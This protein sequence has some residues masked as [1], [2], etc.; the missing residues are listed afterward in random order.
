VTIEAIFEKARLVFV[1]GFVPL[2]AVSTFYR[3]GLQAI[4][5]LF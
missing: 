4:S 3:W 1:V 5:F 2:S